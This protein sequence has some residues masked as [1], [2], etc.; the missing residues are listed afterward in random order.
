VSA[1]PPPSRPE[2]RRAG[3]LFVCLGN[4]C[5]SPLAKALFARLARD[6]GVLDRF[7]VDSCGT[8]GWHA[9]APAD[10][11]SIA[12]AARNGT[13]ME[14]T[15][16]Q[17]DAARDF[18]RF[19][20]LVAMDLANIETLL[21]L[22][23]PREKVSLL[24]SFDPARTGLPTPQHQI[25]DPYHGKD[26]DFDEVYAMTHAACNGLL[27]HLLS[28]GAVPAARRTRS[29]FTLIE[30]LV[31]IAIIALL[32]AILVPALSA[33]RQAAK[34]VACSGRLQQLGVAL[35][36]YTADFPDQLPQVRV[37]VGPGITV[38]IGAL[39]GGKKGTL[40]AYGIEQYGAERRPL[41]R[42]LAIANVQPDTDPGTIEVEAFRSPADVGGDIPFVGHFASMYDGLG[43]SYT[44]NDHMLDNESA[45][46]LIPPQGG[47]MPTLVT[48]TK[49]WVLGPHPIYNY[50]ESGD[51]GMR[52]Y[53]AKKDGG[54]KA[55]LLMMDMHVGGTFDVPRGVVNTTP[56]YTF[57]PAPNWAPAP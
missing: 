7:D 18:A 42:Y 19:D 4:I 23:A 20:H 24:G 39:F 41:N 40:A 1:Q 57:L 52:W 38:N 45:W 5:R 15:A 44:L 50:Q 55:N 2:T 37:P 32:V 46:T 47:R 56:D 35:T 53:G 9:G 10:H 21:S 49:T 3:V 34:N 6:R 25:P 54:T 11:R 8:G 36:G 33:A 30:L 27:D 48:P 16:R 43:S 22:G 17:L 31:V 13:P 14:H 26:R 51:R 28:Q 12:V 29:A